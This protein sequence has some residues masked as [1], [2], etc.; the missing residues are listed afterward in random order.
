M[1]KTQ[2][3]NAPQAATPKGDPVAVSSR[4]LGID[5]LLQVEGAFERFPIVPR[6]PIDASMEVAVARGDLTP[7]GR[8]SVMIELKM[9]A[10]QHASASASATPTESGETVTDDPQVIAT[11]TATYVVKYAIAEGESP[12][13]AD[14]QAFAKTNGLY[15][16]WPYWREFIANSIVRT[17]LP[18]YL[19]PVFKIGATAQPTPKPQPGRSS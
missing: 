1:S 3:T 12:S 10:T 7:Q 16:V 11:V 19:A 2:A 13:E 15:N 4:V 8:V 6:K 14:L 5:E 9:R 17:G 18:S